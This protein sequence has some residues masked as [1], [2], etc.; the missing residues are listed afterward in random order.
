MNI[1]TLS[2]F[3]ASRTGLS[4]SSA[5]AETLASAY[6]AILVLS[7]PR[8][9]VFAELAD[10]ENLPRWAGGFCERVYVTRG[11]WAA[12]T[13]LGELFLSLD[14][15]EQT[16]EITVWAGWDARDLR[17]LPMQ[18]TPA[19]EGGTVLR[20]SVPRVHDEDHARLCRAL[21]AEW[22]GLFARLEKIGALNAA[23]RSN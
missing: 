7:A 16:G 19:P 5:G 8:E 4:L 23:W 9:R 15:N 18:I 12:L 10:I 22:P 3:T 6:T 11:R 21:S 13:S 2:A 1:A 14:A 20:F 17:A